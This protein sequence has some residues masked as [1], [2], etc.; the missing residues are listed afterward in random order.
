MPDRETLFEAFMQLVNAVKVKPLSASEKADELRRVLREAFGRKPYWF[1]WRQSPSLPS[2][3]T[4]LVW[5]E[6]APSGPAPDY[7]NLR[8]THVMD[9][10]SN[11]VGGYY[12]FQLASPSA[13]FYVEEVVSRSENRGH[14]LVHP[15]VVFAYY[16]RVGKSSHFREPSRQ[17]N[18]LRVGATVTIYQMSPWKQIKAKVL[19]FHLRPRY[20]LLAIE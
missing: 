5:K 4:P 8:A 15:N 19:V 9:A 14:F 17:L 6:F 1:L 18:I 13:D 16:R 3:F 7:Y 11:R 12:E 2:W 10:R 20:C